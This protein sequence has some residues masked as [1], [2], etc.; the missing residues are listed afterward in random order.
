VENHSA[1][2]VSF[3]RFP[4][5]VHLNLDR[6]LSYTVMQNI[7]DPY[8]NFE[9]WEAY[10]HPG[11]SA[12]ANFSFNIAVDFYLAPSYYVNGI[13]RDADYQDHH[14]L[15][16]KNVTEGSIRTPQFNVSGGWGF[17]WKKNFKEV[18]DVVGEVTYGFDMVEYGLPS[19]YTDVVRGEG[20]FCWSSSDADSKWLLAAKDGDEMST[21]DRLQ[22]HMWC[23]P[24]YKLTIPITGIPVLIAVVL[25]ILIIVFCVCI[26]WKKRKRE[27]QANSY[28]RI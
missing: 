13:D 20:D 25:E 6:R 15:V 19:N 16:L 23:V 7:S 10:F 11:A 9:F 3:Y 8:Q 22:A 5:D 26:P 12:V 4:Q 18:K 2:D 27:Q 17:V 28:Q 1:T 21:V 24:R 14:V